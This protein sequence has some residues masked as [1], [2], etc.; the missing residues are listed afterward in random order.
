MHAFVTSRLDV[1]NAWL[2][3]ANP[4]TPKSGELGG[5]PRGWCHEVLPP[6]TAT[7]IDSSVTAYRTVL[8][9]WLTF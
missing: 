4:M 9:M 1:G 7:E 3:R 8:L 2:Y 6:N 5:L